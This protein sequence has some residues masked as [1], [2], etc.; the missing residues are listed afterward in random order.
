MRVEVVLALAEAPWLV[1]VELETGATVAEAIARSGLRERHPGI[2]VDD[3]H[4]GIWNRKATL[5][6]PLR[7]HDRVEIHRDL[8]ADPKL[9]RRRRAEANPV[10]VQARRRVSRS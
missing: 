10:G 3:E 1:E 4:V 6:T 7:E 2:V 8:V 9:A 5:A